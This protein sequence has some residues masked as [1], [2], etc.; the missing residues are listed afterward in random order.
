MRQTNK[1]TNKQRN[2]HVG[3]GA[4]LEL[5]RVINTSALEAPIMHGYVILFTT[6]N[7]L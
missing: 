1:Q 6:E 4:A 3:I 5:G 7:I 2:R